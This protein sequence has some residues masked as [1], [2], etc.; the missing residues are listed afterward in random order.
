[1]ARRGDHCDEVRPGVGRAHLAVAWALLPP[2]VTS[3]IVGARTPVQ[4]AETVQAAAWQL[5]QKDQAESESLLKN[6][7]RGL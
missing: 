6:W 7:E 2:E 1:M 3:A 5:S 4:I